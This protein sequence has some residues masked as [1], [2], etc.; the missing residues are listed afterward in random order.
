MKL[1]E[2]PI[3]LNFSLHKSLPYTMR[4]LYGKS[5]VKTFRLYTLGS[6]HV[7][8]I[9]GFDRLD[10]VMTHDHRNIKQDEID[11]V[12]EALLPSDDPSTLKISHTAKNQIEGDV[13]KKIRVKDLVI[14]EKPLK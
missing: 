9:E 7:Y 6:V 5:N 10:I 11:F 4:Y 12:R 1:I 13:H 3:R 2:N 14:I 8:S